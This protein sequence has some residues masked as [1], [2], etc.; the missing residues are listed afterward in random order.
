MKTLQLGLCRPP[1]R[2]APAP[3]PLE[4]ADRIIRSTTAETVLDPFVGSGTTAIAARNN[5]RE[6][7]GIDIS[8]EYIELA[9]SRAGIE[10][11]DIP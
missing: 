8:R 2:R 11:A 7:I 5:Q 6:F 1:N 9:R 10:P 3:F 4:L